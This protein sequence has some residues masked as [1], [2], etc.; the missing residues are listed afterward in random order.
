M[1]LVRYAAVPSTPWKNGLGLTRQLAVH[2]AGAQAEDFE[3]RVSI[4]QLQ[5]TAT[6]SRFAGITRCLAVLEGAL[7]LQ[8]ADRTVSLTPHSAPLQ[9]SGE[10][11]ATGVVE[12]SPAL[13]LNVMW[14]AARWRCTL[15]RLT[16][17]AGA[18]RLERLADA[19]I[20][21]SLRPGLWLCSAGRQLSLERYDLVHGA[22]RL[23]VL[24]PEGFDAY[25]IEL[26]QA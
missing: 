1:E 12:Q 5:G 10:A 15:S 23:T 4:A 6:F 24:E 16:G 3:W 22:S 14:H 11:A 18:A 17:S 2:P 21:C 20:L 7:R 13:D 8:F 26:Q 19:C 9:F 25:C